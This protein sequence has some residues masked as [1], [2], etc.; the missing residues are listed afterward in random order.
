MQA[1]SLTFRALSVVRGHP[2]PRLAVVGPAR[3]CV[4]ASPASSGR[5]GGI[6]APNSCL[7][8]SLTNRKEATG[9]EMSLLPGE[10]CLIRLFNAAGCHQWDRLPPLA[11]Q[12]YDLGGTLEELVATT[13]FLV[14]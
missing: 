1:L 5:G 12:F 14:T 8:K 9:Q 13:R 11:R 4:G 10:A 3:A 6:R 7:A 2:P